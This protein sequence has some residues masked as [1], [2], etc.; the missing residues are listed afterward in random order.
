VTIEDD[1]IAIGEF[2]HPTSGPRSR[3]TRVIASCAIENRRFKRLGIALGSR[4]GRSAAVLLLHSES[5][6]IWAARMNQVFSQPAIRSVLILV[7]LAACVVPLAWA[8]TQEAPAETAFGSRPITPAGSLVL[9]ATTGMPAVGSMPV[10]FVRSPDHAAKDGGGRYLIAVNSGYGI[11]FTAPGNRA[12]QSL[13]VIDL[14]AQPAA[15]VIEDVYFPTPQSANVGAVFSPQPGPDGSYTL[16]V[17]GG[18]ENK[19]WMF[20]FHPLSA[21]PL[22][23]PSP[24]P[25]TKVTAPSIS[26]KSLASER[27]SPR[28]Q[29]GMEAVY[30]TGLAISPDGTTLYVANNLGDS[31]GIIENLRGEPRLMRVDLSDGLAGHFVYPYAVVAWA[32]RQSRETQR[33]YVSCWATASVAVVGGLRHPG[34]PV[35]SIKVG[36]HPT[37]ML[38]NAARTR[39]YV[40]NSDADT[41]SVIDTSRDRVIETIGVRLGEKALPGS[42]PESLALSENGS[43]LYVAN[44]HSNAVAVVALS[45]RARGTVIERDRTGAMSPRDDV[46][47]KDQERSVVRG[48]VPTG[49]YPS[50]LAVGDGILFVGNGKGTGFGD[51]SL[52]ANDSGRAPNAPNDRFPAGT[53]RQRQGGQYDISLVAG[54]FSMIPE[55]DDRTLADDSSQVLRNDGLMGAAKVQLFPG[56]SPIHHIIYVIKENRS[57]DQLFGDLAQAGNGARADGDPDLAIFGSG[58]AAQRPGGPPQNITPNAHALALR[59]GLMDRFFVNSEASPDGHNWSTA[60]FS[61][62][63]VDKA[64]RSNY[65]GRGRPYDFQGT[66]REPDL[67]PLKGQPPALAVPATADDIANYMRR[68]LPY[69]HGARDVAEP[70]TL[71]LWDDADHA[72]LSYRTFGEFVET[73]SQAQV[74]SFNANRAREYP[75]TSPTVV[76]FPDKRALENHSSAIHR[77]FDLLTPDSMTTESYRAAKESGGRIDPLI[78][79]AN[80]DGRYRGYSRIGG[81]LEE[82]RRSVEGA[83]KGVADALPAFNIVYLPNDHTN[84]LTSRTPTPQFYVAENDYALGLLVEEVSGSPYWR[85]TAIFVVEDDAQDGPDHVDAH[86]APALV[87]SAYNRPGALVHGYH[88]TVSLIRTMERLL[89]MPPMNQLD[90]AATP[91]D[92]FQPDP[93][94]RPYKATLPDLSLE[95]LIVRPSPDRE[96][97]R[98]IRL[99]ERQDLQAADRADPQVLNRIIWFSVRGAER[100]YPALVRMPVFDVMRT[101]LDEEA[102]EELSLTRVMDRLLARRSGSEH[103]RS[104]GPS[105]REALRSR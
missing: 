71:Y 19:I 51:S 8:Q 9:D 58:P 40:A 28:Y 87:V 10:N 95:N 15:R 81:W 102:D 49:Q 72:R 6:K 104:P 57:Y 103:P 36:R 83:Q 38:V 20:S 26:L 33:V 11:Q 54:D 52:V 41:V 97:A 32:P 96:T 16:Y 67:W 66:N 1:E 90:A 31:L 75:D 50:A 105:P 94:L 43:T 4:L 47:R 3:R 80:S 84:A 60:A 5:S 64:F 77:A 69:L 62:D 61:T 17:S 39:L 2:G 88:S 18:Y 79:P 12:Q 65:S 76:A 29:K 23:P 59:F 30:P 35:A 92:I 22:S 98:W 53:G 48:F 44:A 37:E 27:A 99:S 91:I 85:D 86:R 78:S 14:E 21:L 46:D 13:A 63:Y 70:E 34:A 25:D 89:G 45:S 100:S 68:F 7:V 55:P 73:I 24:G 56:A 74:D 82:F 101:R 42:S 93:D